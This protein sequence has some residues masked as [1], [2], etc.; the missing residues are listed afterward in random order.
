MIYNISLFLAKTVFGLSGL[1]MVA[2]D[3][4]LRAIQ[5]ARRG[6]DLSLHI[7]QRWLKMQEEKNSLGKQD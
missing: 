1:P 5:D 3:S 6:R 7:H 2:R 4:V